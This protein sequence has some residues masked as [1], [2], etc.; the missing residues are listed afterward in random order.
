MSVNENRRYTLLHT[1]R[2]NVK[3]QGCPALF[4]ALRVHE[5]SHNSNATHF[6][7]LLLTLSLSLSL[8]V[9]AGSRVLLL[10]GCYFS[11]GE[12]K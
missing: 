1:T 3:T 7:F 11:K 8:P 2:R 10:V 4:Q 5:R 12:L 6:L 9:G